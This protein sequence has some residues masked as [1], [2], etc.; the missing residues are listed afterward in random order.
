MKTTSQALNTFIHRYWQAPFFLLM[1]MVCANAFA[2]TITELEKQSLKGQVKS[3]TVQGEI[4]RLYSE[5]Q[6]MDQQYRALLSQLSALE[7]SNVEL[8]KRI[9][10]QL[11]QQS[12]LQQQLES[13]AQIK[14]EITPL[15]TQMQHSL[16][17]FV[18]A[19]LPFLKAQRLHALQQ[20]DSYL[21]DVE[22]P[23]SSKYQKLLEAFEEQAELGYSMTSYQNHPRYRRAGSSDRLPGRARHFHWCCRPASG[24]RN[25]IPGIHSGHQRRR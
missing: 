25:R 22:N 8:Q 19:D 11:S 13:V 21:A 10:S 17:E 12:N 16:V 14:R 4:D 7:S 15:M 6:Q 23:L 20:L 3:A 18:Q 24:C 9:D 1:L 2:S 5:E